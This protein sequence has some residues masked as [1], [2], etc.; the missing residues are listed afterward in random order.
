MKGMKKQL[1]VYITEELSRDLK[2]HAIN[3]DMSFSK[4]VETAVS[5][6]IERN[7]ETKPVEVEFKKPCCG[8][9]ILYRNH[10][11]RLSYD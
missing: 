10:N 6:W 11:N 9:D 3:R 5:E 1:K 2:V 7:V 4:L 8:K